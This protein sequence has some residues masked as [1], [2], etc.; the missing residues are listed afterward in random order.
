MERKWT[1]RQYHVPDNADIAH[2]YVKMYC[3]TNQFPSLLFCGLYSKPRSARVLSKN[4]YLRFDPKL[5]NGI[6]AIRLIPCEFAPFTS[7][8]HKYWI[9][10]I[11]SNEHDLYKPVTKCIYYPFLVSF[12]NLNIIPLS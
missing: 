8:I 5:G 9:Y 4:Y 10:R 12:K 6:C 1:D 2:K 7:M 3:N 11:P